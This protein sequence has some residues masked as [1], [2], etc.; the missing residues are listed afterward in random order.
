MSNASETTPSP[1]RKISRQE[2][3]AGK[4]FIYVDDK[5]I[6]KRTVVIWNYRTGNPVVALDLPSWPKDLE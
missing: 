4:D 3:R 6:G 5:D 2:C 1:W